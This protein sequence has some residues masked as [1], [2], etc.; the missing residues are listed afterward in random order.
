[1][2]KNEEFFETFTTPKFAYIIVHISK[3]ILSDVMSS[4]YIFFNFFVGCYYLKSYEYLYYIAFTKLF[5]I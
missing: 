1:M 3:F 2:K 4:L 5:D